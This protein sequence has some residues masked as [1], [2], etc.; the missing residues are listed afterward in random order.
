M[1]EPIVIEGV[2]FTEAEVEAMANTLQTDGHKLLARVYDTVLHTLGDQGMSMPDI[3][4]RMIYECR[5]SYQQM[6]RL[7]SMRV[8]IA[9]MAQQ[10][11]ADR[12]AAEAA[13]SAKK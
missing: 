6:R 10:I 5:G 3:T 9:Q 7:A 8:A 2:E 1:F 12:R 11:V 13:K 4:D